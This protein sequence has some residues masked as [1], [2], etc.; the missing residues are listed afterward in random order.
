MKMKDDFLT[1]P[2]APNY[3]INSELLV[4][5]KKTGKILKSTIVDRESSVGVYTPKG[6]QIRRFVTTL[7]V[8]AVAGTNL[9]VWKP[10]P[11]LNGKYE[12]HKIGL[13]RN[14]LNKKKLRLNKSKCYC[15]TVNGKERRISRQNLL[16]E[17]YGVLPKNRR[18]TI[19]V[20][21]DFNG[22]QYH[23]KSIYAAAKYLATKVYYGFDTLRIYLSK[24]VGEIGDYKITYFSPATLGD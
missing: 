20:K 12:L 5:N 13:L 15:V 7:R 14:A 22:T 10:V 18:S 17:V 21:V 16:Y 4:R 3:E 11:S 2:D 19:A 9:N 1:I 23:F 24:R 8:Q 6:N